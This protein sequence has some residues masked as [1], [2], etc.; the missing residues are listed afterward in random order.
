MGTCPCESSERNEPVSRVSGTNEVSDGNET[1]NPAPVSR[2]SGTNEVSDG[3]E[4]NNPAPVTQKT[5]TNEV[6]DG[7]ETNNPAPVSRV[8]G[9]NEV[10]DGNETNNPAPVTEKPLH[11]HE[12]HIEILRGQ[13]TDQELA[14]LI[15]VLGSISGSTPPAQPEPTRWGLPVDQLRYPVFSWQRITLQEMTHMRR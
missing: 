14:A 10:S 9:T 11:P 7:N 2:V 15:A 3:N 4:T 6:S 13:P 1:N 12:P 5:R 8:S